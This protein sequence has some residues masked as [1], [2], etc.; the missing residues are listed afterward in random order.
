LS[1]DKGCFKNPVRVFESRTAAADFHFEPEISGKAFA[2]KQ[3]TFGKSGGA[4]PVEAGGG[5]YQGS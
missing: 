3:K 4:K 2:T 5:K 1:T